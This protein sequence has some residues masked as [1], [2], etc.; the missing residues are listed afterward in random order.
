MK[1]I[2]KLLCVILASSMIAFCFTACESNNAQTSSGASEA[3]DN[4]IEFYIVRHGEQLFNTTGQMAGWCD[5]PLTDEGVAQSHNLGKAFEAEGI[6]F[7]VE[8]NKIEE[9]YPG[10]EKLIRELGEAASQT[11]NGKTVMDDQEWIDKTMAELGVP[12]N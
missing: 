10:Y 3:Q 12:K 8:G 7:D 1:T 11:A 5:S 2:K 4:A 6:D 9:Q